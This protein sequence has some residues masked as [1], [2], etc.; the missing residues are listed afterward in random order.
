MDIYEAPVD[1]ATIELLTGLSRAWEA[2]R[3][4]YGY[5]ANTRADIENRRVFLAVEG[6]RT[7]GYLF[8]HIYKDKKRSATSAEYM[9]CECFEVEELYVVPEMRGR[10]IGSALFRF[11]EAALMRDVEFITL[12]SA[13]TNWRAALHLCADE[14][15]M[16]VHSARMFKRISDAESR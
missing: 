16:E 7:A 15:G 6:G 4:C 5:R 8:G 11:A 12:N 14:L 13:A 3:S 10:G 1:D 9:G 2:E